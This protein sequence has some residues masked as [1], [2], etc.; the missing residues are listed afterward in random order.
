MQEEIKDKKELIW[1]YNQDRQNS[2]ASKCGWKS[3]IERRGLKI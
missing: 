2:Y 3:E 1:R